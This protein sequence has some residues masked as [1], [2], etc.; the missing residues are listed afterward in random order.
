MFREIVGEYIAELGYDYNNGGIRQ[1]GAD[2]K[3]LGSEIQSAGQTLMAAITLPIAGLATGAVMA[4]SKLET[5]RTNFETLTGSIEEGNNLYKELVD[6]SAKT[7]FAIEGL[8]KGAQ[9]LMAFGMEADKVK[10]TIKVLGDISLGNKERFDSLTLAFSQAR[11]VGRLMGQDLLQMVNA[12]FNP[13]NEISKKTG[14]SMRQLKDEMSK[15]LITFDQ[16]EQAFISATEEGGKFYKGLERGAETTAGKFSTF[17]DNITLALADIGDAIKPITDAMLDFGIKAA[18]ALGRVAKLFKALPTPIKGVILVFTGIIALLPVLIFLVG[19]AAVAFGQLNI[20]IGA[21]VANKALILGFLNTMLTKFIEI[22]VAA[23][24]IVAPILAVSAIIAGLIFLV[25]ILK[26]D[27]KTWSEGG[28]SALGGLWEA[29][30]TIDDGM[31]KIIDDLV[32]FIWTLPDEFNKAM[33]VIQEKTKFLDKPIQEIVNFAM[34]TP[35]AGLDDYSK[36]VTPP[37]PKTVNP[38][39]N[40]NLGSVKV[41]VNNTNAT[42]QQIG[43]ATQD[44]VEQAFNSIYNNNYNWITGY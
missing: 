20:A 1:F 28:E 23:W 44:G 32:M 12:G 37:Q 15:G 41:E 8:A 27:F 5:L 6:F 24:E 22:A 33:G 11:S 25:G 40:A 3:Q 43:E 38:T 26:D 36:P 2:I 42:P 39:V 13:L 14:K 35:G 10:G 21:I 31:T 17:K 19:T 16:V 9:T 7:P 4:S 29:I 18:Q 34:G 30:K